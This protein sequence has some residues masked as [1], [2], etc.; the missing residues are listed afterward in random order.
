MITL[1]SFFLTDHIENSVVLF[2]LEN[3][4]VPIESLILPKPSGP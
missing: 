2:F 4:V 1:N 3:S